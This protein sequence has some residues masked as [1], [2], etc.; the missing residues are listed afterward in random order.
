MLYLFNQYAQNNIYRKWWLTGKTFNFTKV[1]HYIFIYKVLYATH[2]THQLRKFSSSRITDRYCCSTPSCCKWIHHSEGRYKIPHPSAEL[3]KQTRP[4]PEMR[5]E[6]FVKIRISYA[7]HGNWYWRFS[8][9][10]NCTLIIKSVS[11]LRLTMS[12][13]ST[14]CSQQLV[15]VDYHVSTE[16]HS[17]KV[18]SF[19]F[20][21]Y[22]ITLL[23][24]LM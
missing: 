8:C 14:I 1:S 6:F 22:F 20:R 21:I 17:D 3:M 5:T 11:C 2:Y 10:I 9:F 7:S 15:L 12:H 23:L 16:K 24:I 18:T 13:F 4:K 19:Y